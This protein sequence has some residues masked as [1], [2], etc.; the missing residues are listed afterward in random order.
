MRTLVL[1]GAGLVVR[2]AAGLVVVDAVGEADGSGD[3]DDGDGDGDGDGDDD[4]SSVLTLGEGVALAV[5]A[6]TARGWLWLL[7]TGW[8]THLKKGTTPQI[9]MST[10]RSKIRAIL[11]PSSSQSLKLGSRVAIPLR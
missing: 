6:A 8:K 9:M 4:A 11:A 3:S 1:A 7:L 10:T 2:L 5:A